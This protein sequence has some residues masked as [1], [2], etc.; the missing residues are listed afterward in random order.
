[1]LISHFSKVHQDLREIIRPRIIS[2][3]PKNGPQTD[4]C[5]LE[6]AASTD[7]MT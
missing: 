7:V 4:F 1:M 2:N 5:D 6:D 3:R